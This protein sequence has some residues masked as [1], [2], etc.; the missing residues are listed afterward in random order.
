MRFRLPDFQSQACG[1]RGC[2]ID[3]RSP[4]TRQFGKARRRHLHIRRSG[5]GHRR[6]RGWRGQEPSCHCLIQQAV[7]LNR[8][9]RYADTIRACDRIVAGFAVFKEPI[10]HVL[11]V[12]ALDTKG[13][14]LAKTGNASEA[15]EAY[16]QALALLATSPVPELDFL[17]SGIAQRKGLALI[18]VQKP[19]EAI[20]AFDQVVTRSRQNKERGAGAATRALICKA[21]VLHQMDGR[22]NDREFT[23]LLEC[24]AKDNKLQPGWI[25]VLTLLASRLGPNR[26]LELILASPAMSLLLPLVTA[27][28]REVGQETHVAREVDEVAEDIR[29][30][31]RELI[32]DPQ[33]GAAYLPTELTLRPKNEF[34]TVQQKPGA[35]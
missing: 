2:S 35:E 25:T 11:S 16:D 32:H 13:M 12:S 8:V 31:L 15:I 6:R 22:L 5:E 10:M 26:S 17:I 14:A 18:Q 29:H 21:I 7:L 33:A 20:A 24:L 4:N 27:L 3:Q 34:K 30:Q 23:L 1:N 19:M 28:Q 9:G